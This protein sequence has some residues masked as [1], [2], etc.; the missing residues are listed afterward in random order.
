[1]KADLNLWSGKKKMVQIIKIGR[2]VLNII[3][4][5]MK[6]LPVQK[7]VVLISRQSDKPSIEFQMICSEID[8]RE[9]NIKTVLLCKTLDGGVDSSLLNKLLYALHMMKQMYHL[10]TSK[11]VILDS[12]CILA[13]ILRH[14]KELKIIQCRL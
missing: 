4:G 3:Y 2:I 8:R 10:A 9:D 1:M 7:K 6:L 13:S 12:Y 14:K 11:V 5:F